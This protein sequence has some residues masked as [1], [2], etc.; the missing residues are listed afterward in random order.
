MNPSIPRSSMTI[1]LSQVARSTSSAL[2]RSVLQLT[3]WHQRPAL[4]L[5]PAWQERML[6]PIRHQ[7]SSS[8]PVRTIKTIG[9]PNNASYNYE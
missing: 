4:Q 9:T 8:S 3:L 7:P 5:L 6:P 2:N 1:I